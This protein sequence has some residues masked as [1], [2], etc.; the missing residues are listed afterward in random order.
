MVEAAVNIG[1]EDI[2]Y[3][4]YMIQIL[5]LYYRAKAILITIFIPETLKLLIEG[6]NM[7]K[8]AISCWK[9][10]FSAIES[11]IIHF[12]TPA[13]TSHPH[14]ARYLVELIHSLEIFE[15]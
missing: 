11:S 1:R 8:K 13:Y 3:N 4:A 6:I 9:R 14:S 7:K 5:T 15:D 12:T 2:I 10:F